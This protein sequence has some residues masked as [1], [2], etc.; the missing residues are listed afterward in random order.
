ME[1]TLPLKAIVAPAA[2]YATTN[3]TTMPPTTRFTLSLLALTTLAAC[4]PDED[5]VAPLPEP[6]PQNLNV[7]CVQQP[8]TVGNYWVYQKYRVDSIDNVVRCS[9]WTAFS[10]PGIRS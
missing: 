8:G 9:A 1:I 2:R 4:Q 3:P 10:L 6:P 5:V 7:D